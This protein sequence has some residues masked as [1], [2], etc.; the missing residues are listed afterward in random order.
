MFKIHLEW[1]GPLPNAPV[2]L[3]MEIAGETQT[4]SIQV[5]AAN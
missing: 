5:V 3:R 1:N 4:T 2:E